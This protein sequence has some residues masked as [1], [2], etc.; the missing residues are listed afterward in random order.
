MRTKIVLPFF[1]L[2]LAAGCVGEGRIGPVTLDGVTD[3]DGDGWMDFEDCDDAEPAANP[4]RIEICNDGVDN[5]CDGEMGVCAM[6]WLIDLSEAHGVLVGEDD[7]THA[8]WSV[9]GVGD[10][11]GDGFDD[12]A[13]GSWQDDEGGAYAGAVYVVHGPITGSINGLLA[14]AK[15][16]GAEAGDH[17][18][19][20]VAGAGD[21]NRDGYA[22]L[23]VGGYGSEG[24]SGKAWIVHGPVSGTVSLDD[25]DAVLHGAAEYDYFGIAVVGAGDLDG[26]GY[27][28][29]AV[30]AYGVDTPQYLDAGAVYVFHGPLLG[31]RSAEMADATLLGA[32]NGDWFG[33]SLAAA[34]DATGDGRPDLVVGAPGVVR[35]G[36]DT[37]AVYVFRGEMGSMMTAAGAYARVRGILENDRAGSAVGAGDLDGDGITDL[38][39]GAWGSDAGAADGG[40]A[41]VMYGPLEGSRDLENAD[42]TFA[43]DR[44]GDALGFSV[45][46]AR[47]VNGDGRDDL[48]V[49]SVDDDSGGPDSG[50][51]WILYGPVEGELGPDDADVKLV[52]EVWD[53]HAGASVAGLGDVDGDGFGDVVIGAHGNNRGGSDSGAAY[54]V[55]GQGF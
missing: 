42:A 21:V 22:D 11:N 50:A 46:V 14:D 36:P 40:A 54:V 48:V 35:A 3:A 24:G 26:D 5:D 9:A 44:P 16:V 49:G 13:V 20:S 15:L 27:P 25:A 33:S 8:G 1:L 29:V 7:D 6:D 53:D 45:A 18:G 31:H 28:D 32:G 38:A 47:D 4:G 10:V 19:W 51:A 17:A 23:V 34:A 41:F 52:G 2:V 39:V 55:C 12:V 43:A 30:G 37:G